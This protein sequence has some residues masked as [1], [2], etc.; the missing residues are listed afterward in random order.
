MRGYGVNR[1][2]QR[3]PSPFGC[4]APPFGSRKDDGFAAVRSS[5]LPLGEGDQM[6]FNALSFASN[7]WACRAGTCSVNRSPALARSSPAN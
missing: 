7:R 5:L 4:F 3:N 1:V 2:A 6:R